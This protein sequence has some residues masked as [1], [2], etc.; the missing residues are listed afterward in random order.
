MCKVL[1]VKINMCLWDKHASPVEMAFLA[2]GLIAGA[3]YEQAPMR[4]GPGVCENISLLTRNRKDEGRVLIQDTEQLA[5]G[6]AKVLA[7]HRNIS[8][9]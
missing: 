9:T 5:E 4:E 6:S 3:F 2:L 1:T 7:E 8:M